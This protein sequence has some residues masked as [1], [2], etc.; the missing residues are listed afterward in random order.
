MGRFINADTQLNLDQ[1]SENSFIYCRNNPLNRKDPT[2]HTWQEIEACLLEFKDFL[3][4]IF[5]LSFAVSQM[6]SPMPGPCDAVALLM[7]TAG[8]AT[9]AVATPVIYLTSKLQSIEKDVA[10]EKTIA[11]S[12]TKKQKNAVIFPLNPNDY[13]PIGLT[14]IPGKDTKNGPHYHI[15]N[16]NIHYYPGEEVPEPYA[17]IYFPFFKSLLNNL[18]ILSNINFCANKKL[19]EE[20]YHD[21]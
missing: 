20:K 12:A 19:C 13:Y 6:D 1:L 10:K 3:G 21:N 4:E 9:C 15:H 18:Y 8:D 2:G 14:K 16:L 17:S 7:I 11:I 5:S